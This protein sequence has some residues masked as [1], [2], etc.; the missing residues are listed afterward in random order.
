MRI[1]FRHRNSVFADLRLENDSYMIGRSSECDIRIPLDFVSR[2]H[3]KIF[4]RDGEFFYQDLRHEH[5]EYKTEAVLLDD[6]TKIEIVDGLELVSSARVDN[7]ETVILTSS[8]IQR[9]HKPLIQATHRSTWMIAVSAAAGVFLLAGLS[10]LAWSTLKDLTEPTPLAAREVFEEVKPKVFEFLLKRNDKAIR[11]F[12]LY[13]ELKDEDFREEV[14]YCTGFA[15]GP[16]I[17]LTASHCVNG[18]ILAD[19]LYDIQLKSHDGKIHNIDRVLGYDL[20]YDYLFLESKSLEPYGYLE[21]SQDDFRV[22]RNVYTVG[23]V[24]GEGL[25]IREGITASKTKDNNDP[26]IEFIRFSAAASGGNSGGPLVDEYGNVVALVFGGNWG[27]NYNLGTD[28]QV[29]TEAKNRFVDSG[30]KS[31]VL[32]K[33]KRLL[34][35]NIYGLIQAFQINLG[36]GLYEMPEAL[37]GFEAIEISM[38]LPL[39]LEEHS[40]LLIEKLNSAMETAW[41]EAKQKYPDEAL[42]TPDW[43]SQVS[44]DYPVSFASQAFRELRIIPSKSKTKLFDEFLDLV[45]P[46]NLKALELEKKS[47]K[48][49][50]TYRSSGMTQQLTLMDDEALNEKHPDLAFYG[51]QDFRSK[52]SL[53]ALSGEYGAVFVVSL[54]PEVEIEQTHIIEALIGKGLLSGAYSPLIRPVSQREFSINKLEESF[55]NFDVTDGQSRTWKSH[56]T[57]LFGIHT[58]DVF[59]LEMTQAQ[60]CVPQIHNSVNPV[61]VEILR[62]RFV[63]AKLSHMVPP[64]RFI[65]FD[66]VKTHFDSP[67][68]PHEKDFRVVESSSKASLSFSS[69]G[70]EVQLP[71][72]QKIRAMRFK[73]AFYFD[74]GWRAQEVEVLYGSSSQPAS[75]A[76]VLGVEVFDFAVTKTMSDHKNLL[77][78]EKAGREMLIG[79]PEALKKYEEQLNRKKK[80][81]WI[82]DLKTKSSKPLQI[83]GQCVKLDTQE[84]NRLRYRK[85][86]GTESPL[87]LEYKVLAVN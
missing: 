80:S 38:P 6:R 20:K 24:A 65:D 7:E 15:V 51:S 61:L 35:F 53:Y 22:G 43:S 31:E 36:E 73:P 76:C 58:L 5:P 70:L 18:S 16:G 72:P 4:K 17:V 79:K 75:K 33:P 40:R 66:T 8:H 68:L 10:F 87:P 3:G 69:I 82:Q 83:F 77:S 86:Y 28:S 55:E 29:L 59:C 44:A 56:S 67:T 21:L 78:G 47:F 32:L 26:S 30:R 85:L 14:G 64:S 48:E 54:K 71:E 34:N 42:S 37:R 63:E 50:R 52:S 27:G 62:K 25:A 57:Q 81:L 19:V 45:L 13:A 12:K 46:T 11:D 41:E 1:I 23:N 39:S 9:T 84:D 74:G 60:L 2:Q 49:S